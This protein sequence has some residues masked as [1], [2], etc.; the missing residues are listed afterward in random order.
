MSAILLKNDLISDMAH[1][2]A[3]QINTQYWSSDHYA[4]MPMQ[5]AA[6][7]KGCKMIILDDKNYI[8]LIVSQNIDR[9]YA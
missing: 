8:F 6:S 5:Y 4:N 1:I 7:F 3:K 2:F 9:G